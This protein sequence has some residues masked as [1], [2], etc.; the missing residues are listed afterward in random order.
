MKIQ[1]CEKFSEVNKLQTKLTKAF[2]DDTIIVK[3]C[4]SMCKLCKKQ[5]AVKVDGKKQKA[6]R[7]SKLISKIDGL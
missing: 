4:I 3:S 7:I 2:P 5:P 1:I 6:K